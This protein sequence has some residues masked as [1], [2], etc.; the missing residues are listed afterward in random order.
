MSILIV[1]GSV[2]KTD[3]FYTFFFFE[4]GWFSNFPSVE[5]DVYKKNFSKI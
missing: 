2:L 5:L 4:H 3:V 1:I